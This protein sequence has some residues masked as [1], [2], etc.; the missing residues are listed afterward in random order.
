MIDYSK[1][2]RENLINEIKDLHKEI[3]KL[4]MD[5]EYLYNELD[6]VSD[7]LNLDIIDKLL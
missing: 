1:Y 5:I 2:T 3:E 6:T 7:V 4:L